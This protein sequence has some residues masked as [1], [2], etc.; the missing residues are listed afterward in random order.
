MWATQSVEGMVFVPF[1]EANGFGTDN[2]P[3]LS[4]PTTFSVCAN[5]GF[6]KD[7]EFSLW[8]L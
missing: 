4:R 3:A 1:M 8:T 5:T 6:R 7:T 2:T